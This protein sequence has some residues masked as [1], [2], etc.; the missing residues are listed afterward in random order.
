MQANPEPVYGGGLRAAR[1]A[2]DRFGLLLPAFMEHVRVHASLPKQ[3]L[4]GRV[5]AWA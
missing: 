5:R 4:G 2:F 3:A 1:A